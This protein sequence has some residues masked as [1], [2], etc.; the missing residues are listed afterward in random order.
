MLDALARIYDGAGP[1]LGVTYTLF[2]GEP[3]FAMSVAL[4][5]ES[6]TALFQAMPDDD[7]LA[8][9]I[10]TPTAA[11]EVAADVSTESPW[12]GCLGYGV[13]WAWALTN[14]QG[15]ADGVRFEFG[16]PNEAASVIVELVVVASAI[17]LFV[18]REAGRA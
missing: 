7:T 15:Y 4:R 11:D 6:L 10:G 3:G 8:V 14:Q 2:G 18:S 12:A 13:S 9:N 1:L 16:R 5:F 17:R